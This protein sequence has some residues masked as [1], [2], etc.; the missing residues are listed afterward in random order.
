MWVRRLD[1][2]KFVA[3]SL[4]GVHSDTAFVSEED[5]ILSMARTAL[6]RTVN[7][8][9][10]TNVQLTHAMLGGASGQP[11]Y[12]PGALDPVLLSL[13]FTAELLSKTDDLIKLEA[14]IKA[15][16]DL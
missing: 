12:K 14:V 15:E 10:S 16:L 1:V 7:P 8:D 4:S 5:K 2:I 9:G 11:N 13:L 3:N 6:V